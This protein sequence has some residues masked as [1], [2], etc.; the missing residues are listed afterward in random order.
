MTTVP[1]RRQGGLV[2]ILGATALAGVSGYAIQ[3]LAAALIPSAADYLSF[4]AFWSTLFLLGTA[5]GGVQQEVARASHPAR[6]EELRRRSLRPFLA[7]AVAVVVVASTIVGVLVGPVAFGI[8]DPMLVV[9]LVIGLLGYVVT[10]VAT[11][12]FY[13]VSALGSVAA[14]IAVDAALRGIAVVSGLV[15]GVG[16]DVL[17]FAI[18]IPFGLAVGLVWLAVRRRMAGAY[19]LD[20]DTPRLAGNALHTVAGAAAIGLMVTGMPVVFRLALPDAPAV[21]VASLTLVVT[22][23]RAPFI[24]PVMALQSYLIVGFRAVRGHPGALLRRWGL[25]AG[26][27]GAVAMTLAWLLGPWAVEFVSAGQYAVDGL[28]SA[29]VVLSAVLVGLLC[30]T[31]PALLAEN[32]HGWYSVGWLVAAATALACIGLLPWGPMERALASLLCAPVAGLVVHAWALTL[33]VRREDPVR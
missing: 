9:A 1:E 7:L 28:T 21:T 16:L 12:L 22:L 20:V 17:A 5:V 3:L 14:L 33:R 19:T 13:G 6:R 23:T 32:R 25:I 18:A 31:G 11:G 29:L 10:S 27:T 26:G 8:A 2:Y 15:L 30:V 24:I 4:A